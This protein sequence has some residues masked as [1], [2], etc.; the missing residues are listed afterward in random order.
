MNGRAVKALTRIAA[1]QKCWNH[2][3]PA[4]FWR[5]GGKTS[6]SNLPP[7]KKV[8][9]NYFVRGP[10]NYGIMNYVILFWN[11]IN[12]RNSKRGLEIL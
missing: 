2:E 9:M 6:F 3:T 5:I 4:H 8:A 1:N 10:N 7:G 11:T 12:I